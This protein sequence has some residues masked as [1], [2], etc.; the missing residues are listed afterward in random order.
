MTF[1]SRSLLLAAGLFALPMT[2]ALAQTAATTSGGAAGNYSSGTTPG[3]KT[4]QSSHTPGATGQT[5]VPGNSSTMAG[6][7]ESTKTNQQ[8]AATGSSRGGK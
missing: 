4:G 5:I 8:N 6:D 3:G 2:A 1:S 7:K